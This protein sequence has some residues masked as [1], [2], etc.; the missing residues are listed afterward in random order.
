MAN[1]SIGSMPFQK[2]FPIPSP[3]SSSPRCHPAA[4][5]KILPLICQKTNPRHRSSSTAAGD[6]HALSSP[7]LSQSTVKASEGRSF[8]AQKY[9]TAGATPYVPVRQYRTPYRGIAPPVTIRTAVPVFSAP[10]AS[11][12][13]SQMMRA[14]PVRVAPPV[15]IRQAVPVFAAPTVTKETVASA[16]DLSVSKMPPSRNEETTNKSECIEVDESTALRCLEQLQI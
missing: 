13:P 12:H 7:S 5:S 11:A 8:S 1:S 2:K 14:Q 9:S 15:C 10:P 3:Q 16:P 6:S 4:T